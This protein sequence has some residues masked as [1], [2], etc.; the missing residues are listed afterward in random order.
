M[1]FLL[2]G[3]VHH[4]V[5]EEFSAFGREAR[6]IKAIDRSL[7][8]VEERGDID[9]VVFLGDILEGRGSVR[10]D[11]VNQIAELLVPYIDTAHVPIYMVTGNHDI[12]RETSES[13]LKIFDLLGVK[14]IAKPEL[15][16][17]RTGKKKVVA[18]FLPWQTDPDISH[19]MQHA[20]VVFGHLDVR[21]ARRPDGGKLEGRFTTDQFTK[22]TYLAHFH[23][24]QSVGPN[25]TYVGC[26][27]AQNFGDVLGYGPTII[28]TD[29]L[30]AYELHNEVSRE[31]GDFLTAVVTPPHSVKAPTVDL[32]FLRLRV[33]TDGSEDIEGEAAGALKQLKC[34]EDDNSNK[35]VRIETLWHERDRRRIDVKED[36]SDQDWL[37][38]YV[39]EKAE[40]KEREV[41][42]KMGHSFLEA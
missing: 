32:D 37:G 20:D 34:L 2:I 15:V 26:L 5:Y 31:A 42:L 18:A 6:T 27:L 41:L 8:L 4:R 17:F 10:L 14:V 22:P 36:A 30:G 28:D 24:G 23:H 16:E 40:D 11:L 29:D 38:A 7:S 35:A 33:W 9:V 21:G 19:Y 12:I 13:C 39:D 1:K 25:V 3:D